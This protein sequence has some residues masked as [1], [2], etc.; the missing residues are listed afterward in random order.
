[1]VVTVALACVGRPGETA[2]PHERPGEGDESGL[3]REPEDD[4]DPRLDPSACTGDDLDLLALIEARVCTIPEAEAGPLP[5]AKT[6]EIQAPRKLTVAS[7]KRLDFEIT[8][9]NRSTETLVLD[10]VFRRLLPLSPQ[11]TERVGE[12]EGPDDSCVM[13]AMS[14]EPP[15]ERISLPAKASLAIPSQWYANARLIEPSSY[16]GSECRSFPALAPG[17]YRS[18]FEVS[19]VGSSRREISVEIVVR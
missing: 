7:G 18:V 10:L 2:A 13:R 14:T 11:R 17:R 15:P 4:A 9:H 19:G 16:A 6:L 8:L 1:M 3:L 12:G 5:G